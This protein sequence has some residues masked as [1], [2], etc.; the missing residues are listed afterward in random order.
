MRVKSIV[1]VQVNGC[2]WDVRIR[3]VNDDASISERLLCG[4]GPYTLAQAE[5][6]ADN[7]RRDQ[8]AG[9][10]PFGLRTIA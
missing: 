5:V 6:A 7:A 2:G 8:A 3:V 9:G 4:T 1:P 10:D